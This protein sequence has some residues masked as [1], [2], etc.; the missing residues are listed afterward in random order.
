[1]NLKGPIFFSWQI[2]L[3]SGCLLRSKIKEKCKWISAEACLSVVLWT[4]VKMNKNLVKMIWTNLTISTIRMKNL[5]TNI[6]IALKA[7]RNQQD[8]KRLFFR[9]LSRWNALLQILKIPIQCVSLLLKW[10]LGT[11]ALI[12][13]KIHK[14]RIYFNLIKLPHTHFYSLKDKQQ[15]TETKFTNRTKIKLSLF[16]I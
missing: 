5:K 7:L 1:M 4:L 8:R 15:S 10:V 6:C 13:L 2:N 14:H 11:T 3:I 12:N 9:M 16:K